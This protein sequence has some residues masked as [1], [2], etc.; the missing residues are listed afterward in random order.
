MRVEKELIEIWNLSFGDNFKKTFI[1]QE[2]KR[3]QR[4]L[5]RAAY[6]YRREDLLLFWQLKSRIDDYKKQILTQDKI[7]NELREELKKKV[8]E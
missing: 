1:T 7:I 5:K 3:F 6:K 4:K 2:Y 8:R